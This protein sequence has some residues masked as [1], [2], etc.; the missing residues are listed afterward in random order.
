MKFQKL[1]TRKQA[2]FLLGKQFIFHS[3]HLNAITYIVYTYLYKGHIPLPLSNRV[4]NR[5]KILDC[6]VFRNILYFPIHKS[7]SSFREEGCHQGGKL[8]AITEAGE[9]PC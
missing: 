5:F 7:S 1:K 6:T 9:T 4:N 3:L 2:K 8:S